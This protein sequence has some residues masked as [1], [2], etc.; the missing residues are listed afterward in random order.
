MGGNHHCAVHGFVNSRNKPEKVLKK[1]HV[2]ILRWYT[3]RTL[4]DMKLWEKM[5]N[6][7]GGFKMTM[8]TKVC[9][10]HFAAGYC[11]DVCSIPT[12][13]LKGYDVKDNLKRKDPHSRNNYFEIVR[14]KKKKNIIRDGFEILQENSNTISTPF[15]GDHSYDNIIPTNNSARIV[16]FQKCNRC[17]SLE[18]KISDLKIVINAQKKQISELKLSVSEAEKKNSF[19]FDDISYSDK[20]VSVYTGLQNAK[21]FEWLHKHINGEAKK[22]HYYLQTT[23]QKHRINRKVNTKNAMFLVL[24]KLRLALTDNDLAFRFKISQFLVSNILNT[25]IP[26]MSSVLQKFIYWPTR[27]ETKNAYPKCF[28]KFPNVIG[29]IDCTE[30]AIEIPSLAKAQA[31]TYSTYKSKNTWKVLLC[32]T[33]IGTV[34]FLSKAYGGNASDRFITERCGILDKIVSGDSLMADKGFNISDLLVGKGSQ[35][36]IPPFLKDKGKSSKRNNTKTS[37]VAK[38]RIH[39]E[40]A[41][42]RIKKYHILQNVFPLKR[43]TS[44]TLF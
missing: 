7:Q 25:W 37:N 22:L 18:K 29:I 44:W 24:V 1:D 5:L 20:Y 15:I 23:N 21:L 26:F 43:K 4:Q 32:I 35:L 19:N 12:L 38:A 28:E 40:R 39:V 36:V 33:P 17:I 8:C 6:R 30:G 10:N 41:I 11:S 16:P 13:F 2:G 27:E 31:Q 34:S 42:S 9:S 3:A 14:K